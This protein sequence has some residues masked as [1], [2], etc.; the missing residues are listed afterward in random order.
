M[1]KKIIVTGAAGYIGSDLVKTLL[2]SGYEVIAIDRMYF[3]ENSLKDFFGS[4][5]FKLYKL[6]T[7]TIPESIFKGIFA[8]CDLVS[9]SNDPTGDLFPELTNQI[10]HLG[11]VRTARIAREAGVERYILWST[12]SVYGTGNEFD[13]SEDAP[14]KP[15]TTY[16]R[17]SL[18]AEIGVEALATSSFA[19]SI[20]RNGTVFGLSK[21]MRFDLVLNLMVATAFESRKIVV[22]GGGDQWRP[23]IHLHDI[24]IAVLNLLQ[25]PLSVINRQVF[26]I[27]K[28][29]IQ[30]TPLAFRIRRALEES[31][32]VQVVPDDSDKRNYHTSFT[33]A[34][35][36]LGFNAQTSIEDGAVEI[37]KALIS[38]ICVRNESTSTL[39]W[40]RRLLEAEKLYKDLNIDGSIF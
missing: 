3:S 23:L 32:D 40:Y 6:D 39:K 8:V 1:A 18:D 2:E 34:S 9:L 24:S 30:V 21:R 25:Q 19:V 28:E 20:L 13:L 16:A 14:L 15:L 5:N 35:E 33:K 37:Y 17:A 29:N 4:P 27:G 12:C 36:V 31:I 26:N 22:T 10:N 7:R 11:R 38:G